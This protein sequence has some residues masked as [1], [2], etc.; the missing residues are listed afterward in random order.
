[1]IV[2]ENMKI[3]KIQAQRKKNRYN[4]YV[5]DC[6]SLGIDEYVL[7]KYN[8]KT[9]MEVSDEFIQDVLMA[10]EA[11]KTLNY[12]LNRLSYRQRSEKELRISME[13]KGYD[14]KNI[15]AA[16]DHCKEHGYIDDLKFAQ[17]FVQDKMN[18]NKLG[19][20]RIKYD[21]ILK[22]ISRDIIDQVLVV[23]KDEQLE[24]AREVAYKKF[25]SYKN[26]EKRDIYRKLSAFLQRRGFSFDVISKVVKELLDSIDEDEFYD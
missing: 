5:D 25:P 11:N 26:D 3:T 21:L 1:M 20:K 14:A 24:M 22:G 13:R 23:E 4:I 19:P 12:C 9:G 17:S 2:G 16:I 7:V 10:E 6:F 18:L 8:L 15:D